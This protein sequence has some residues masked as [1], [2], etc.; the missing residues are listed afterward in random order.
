MVHLY[1][2]NPDKRRDNGNSFATDNGKCNNSDD[3]Y[4]KTDDCSC[5]V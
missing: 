3:D 5:W 2:H 1:N 4:L